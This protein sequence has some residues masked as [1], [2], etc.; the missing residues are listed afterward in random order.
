[1]FGGIYSGF[2]ERKAARQQEM[3]ARLAAER[4][5]YA[6]AQAA[7]SR[8]AKR[9]HRSAIEVMQHNGRWFAVIDG[10]SRIP[11]VKRGAA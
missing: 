3:S 4:H 10:E 6:L 5:D 9:G 1:M 7:A 2:N 11:K 8:V